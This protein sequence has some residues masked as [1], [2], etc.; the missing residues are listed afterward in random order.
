MDGAHLFLSLRFTKYKEEDGECT[1]PPRPIICAPR[2]TSQG[3]FFMK[4]NDFDQSP[5][6]EFNSNVE[7]NEFDDFVLAA[8]GPKAGLEGLREGLKLRP[9]RLDGKARKC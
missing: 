5:L 3:Y 1:G 7:D 9:R 8:E 4:S 6:T 2:I